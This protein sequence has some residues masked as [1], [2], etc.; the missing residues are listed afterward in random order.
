MLLQFGIIRKY[1]IRVIRKGKDSYL[2]DLRLRD[3]IKNI[4]PKK[5]K[6]DEILTL[7]K[8]ESLDEIDLDELKTVEDFL[9]IMTM[10]VNDA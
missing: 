10:S 5:K 4:N 7:R 3:Y 2:C 6:M 1:I 8:I 9:V